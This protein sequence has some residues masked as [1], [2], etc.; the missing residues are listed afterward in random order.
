MALCNNP[1]VYRLESARTPRNLSTLLLR[2]FSKALGK[3]HIRGRRGQT[4]W[5][6]GEISKRVPYQTRKR[7]LLPMYLL[8]ILHLS[9]I[10]NR[11]VHP[12]DTMNPAKR[13]SS[14]KQSGNSKQLVICTKSLP[15]IGPPLHSP[16]PSR[17]RTSC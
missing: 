12:N 1:S 5:N 10:P 17:V 8:L 4:G 9:K 13:S 14:T 2:Q 3:T 7:T 16:C 6:D 15:H 11:I